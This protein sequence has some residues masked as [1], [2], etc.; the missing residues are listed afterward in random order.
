MYP[1]TSVSELR[2]A[3][4]ALNM[5]QAQLA[6]ALGIGT[7]TLARHERSTD[8]GQLVALAVECLLRRAAP[9]Q[10]SPAEIAARQ[11]AIAEEKA[12]LRA[13]RGLSSGYTPLPPEEKAR[14]RLETET[15]YARL[16][17]EQGS[18][19]AAASLDREAERSRI[20][21]ARARNRERDRERPLVAALHAAAM[22]AA[23]GPRQGSGDWAPYLAV[24]TAAEQSLGYDPAPHR[25]AYIAAARALPISDDHP[26]VTLPLEPD[27]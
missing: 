12:K 27:A 11:V 16:K 26:L 21:L 2:Y 22:L 9:G 14:R 3:R 24:L 20:A 18:S 25:S 23:E 13:A 1:I 6:A 15:A 4:A 8:V 17:R 19:P 7:S 10:R 5:T